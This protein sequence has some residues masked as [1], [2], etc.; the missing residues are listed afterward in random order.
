MKIAIGNDHA[1]PEYKKAIV[2]LLTSKGIEA[3]NYGTDTFDSVDYPDFR[4]KVAQDVEDKKEDFGI[5]IC[6]SVN[7][8]AMTEN[9]NRGV[10]CSLCAKQELAGIARQNNDAIVIPTPGHFT[11]VPNAIEIVGASIT[12]EID[13]ER[14][15][16]RV[17]NMAG[18]KIS[19]ALG[20]I[21]SR[22]F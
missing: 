1:G 21:L 8:I 7:G 5:V 10:G 17:G 20:Y 3:V 9:K 16:N 2:A 13:G 6:G 12:S 18:Q 15:A 4:H 14:H 19:T 11:E 22:L